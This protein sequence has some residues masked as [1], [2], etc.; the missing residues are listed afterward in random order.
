M[1]ED[2]RETL[3]EY[4]TILVDKLDGVATVTFNRPEKRNA[5]NPRLHREM[6]DVLATLEADDDTRVLIITGA[7]EAFSARMDL[8]E[9]FL[10]GCSQHSGGT[11][12]IQKNIVALRGLGLPRS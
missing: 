6:L 2:H 4:G 5:M 12:E 9:Y 10:A 3:P 7:G 1:D 8:K 11:T